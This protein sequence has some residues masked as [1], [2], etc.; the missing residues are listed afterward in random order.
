MSP[1]DG[2]TEGGYALVA[3]LALMTIIALMATAA[4]PRV[5][6]QYQRELE[7]EAITRGEEV[8]EAIER[9]IRLV[10]REPKSMEE[11]LEGAN[12]PGRTKKVRVLRAYAARDPLSRT[13]DGEW[14]LVPPRGKEIAD[15][16]QALMMYM[17]GRPLPPSP[18]Q[19]KNQARAQTVGALNLGK[20]EEG[21]EEEASSANVP[22]VGVASRSRREAVVLYFDIDHHNDWVF[23]PIFR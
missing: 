7:R 19:W 9:Y 13:D 10:G 22:F 3:L 5:R 2:G 4:A 20:S 11:L 16:Q 15:F 6:Q 1:A 21:S 17:G 18:E 8:S 23:T 14:R 12:P